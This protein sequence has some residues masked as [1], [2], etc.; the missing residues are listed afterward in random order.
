MAP[1]FDKIRQDIRDFNVRIRSWNT[2]Q[3]S[4]EEA[5]EV[6]DLLEETMGLLAGEEG[7]EDESDEDDYQDDEE[8]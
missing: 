2:D 1:E 7:M 6:S 5:D 3:L 8:I 4:D